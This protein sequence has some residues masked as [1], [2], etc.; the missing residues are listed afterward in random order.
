MLTSTLLL[1]TLVC[2]TPAPPQ[3]KEAVV[4]PLVEVV[5]VDG[6]HVRVTL[7]DESITLNTKYGELKVPSHLVKGIEFATR[8]SPAMQD[9]IAKCVSKLGHP[10]F[11]A[12]EDA[13]LALKK[14]G[15]RA[16]PVCSET[17]AKSSDPEVSRRAGEVVTYL[18]GRHSN[19]TVRPLDVVITEDSKIAGT[20]KADSLKVKT[21]PFGEQTV[22]LWDID[23]IK[24]P[25]AVEENAK[26]APTNLNTPDY[27]SKFGT[28]FWFKVTGAAPEASGAGVWGSGPY[29]LDSK[30]AVA[31]V[32]GGLL[33]VGETKVL[34][35]RIVNS[36]ATFEATTNNGVT[37]IQYGNFPTGAYE[38]VRE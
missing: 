21:G 2:A 23:K 26:P 29:T 38:F 9:D 13:T 1:S 33:Q 5:C 3:Q 27:Q 37:T 6:S 31:A 14:I 15:P 25:N 30:I 8:T 10:D 12:R 24:L 19:L 32:H 4:P 22:R 34:R 16:F 7:L 20:I 18:K 35:I 36:P 11:A 17:A 28:E